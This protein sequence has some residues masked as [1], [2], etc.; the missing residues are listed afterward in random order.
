MPSYRRLLW[1]RPCG[2]VATIHDLAPFQVASKYDWKRMFYGRVVARRLAWRQDAIIAIS[3][4]TARD[5]S[6]FFKLPRARTTV[7]YNGIEHER[8]FPADPERAKEVVARE[9][10]LERPFLLYV[11]RL[12]HPGKNHVRLISAFEKFKAESGSNWQ[13]VLSGSDWHGAEAI[14][15]AMKSS[16]FTVDIRALGFVPERALPNLYRAAAAFVYHSL[17]EGFGL[18][19]VE[20]MACGCPVICSMRGALGEVVGDAAAIVEPEDIDS[21]TKQI[22]FV[23]TD[24]KFRE[25]LRAAGLRRARMF[26]WKKTAEE[27][28]KVYEKVSGTTTKSQHPSAR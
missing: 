5:I 20:A 9:F 27:T 12:E 2:L 15:A 16:R 7:V 8:F 17:Y 14:H 13:L 21:L 19:P 10:G 23:A 3:E 18:P 1:P 11:A 25:Q 26:D 28:L 22:Q 24:L 4:N 6:A